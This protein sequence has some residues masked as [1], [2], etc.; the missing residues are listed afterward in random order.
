M[1][2]KQELI[3]KQLDHLW[4]EH[5]AWSFG[6]LASVLMGLNDIDHRLMHITDEDLFKRM[7]ALNRNAELYRIKKLPIQFHAQVNDLLIRMTELISELRTFNHEQHNAD[8]FEKL[9]AYALLVDELKYMKE[10]LE[11]VV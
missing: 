7:V 8:S 10:H 5:P 3:I 2:L 9:L 6:K 1:A 4:R 11:G